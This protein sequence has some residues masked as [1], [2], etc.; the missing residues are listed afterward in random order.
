MPSIR[1]DNAGIYPV[2]DH[3]EEGEHPFATANGLVGTV[4]E[5]ML[6]APVQ[7][8]TTQR[9]LIFLNRLPIAHGMTINRVY[10]NQIEK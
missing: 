3:L 2:E 4:K 6:V 7:P 10:A 9:V 5:R 1:I 8:P